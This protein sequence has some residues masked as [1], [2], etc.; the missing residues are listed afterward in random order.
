MKYCL[1]FPRKKLL[2]P[3]LQIKSVAIGLETRPWVKTLTLGLR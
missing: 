1:D 3:N 2:N